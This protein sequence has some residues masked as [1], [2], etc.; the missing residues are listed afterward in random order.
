MVLTATTLMIIGLT[1]YYLVQPVPPDVLHA[2][3]TATIKEWESTDRNSLALLKK[4]QDSIR[5]FLADYPDHPSAEQIRT[6]QDEVDLS[7]HERRL[8]RRIQFSAL[9]SLSPVERTYINVLTSSS[10]DPEQTVDKLRAFIAVFHTI[11]SSEGTADSHRHASSPVEICVEL[12]K[13]RLKKLEQNIA[14]INAEQEQVVRR[15]LDEAAEWDS[16]DPARAEGIRRGIIELYQH[17]RWATELVE[18]AKRL[19]EKPPS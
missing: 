2:R 3:I 8:E 9:R 11:Q 10:N 19:L 14:E 18:E 16:K 12:A 1:V 17:N 13:R 6:Y 7:E 5:Q 15:R 4:A